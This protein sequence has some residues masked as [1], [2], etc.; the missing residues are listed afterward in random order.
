MPGI[1]ERYKKNIA[2]D[3]RKKG[4]SY[5]EIENRLYVPKSTLSFWLRK[6][7]LDESQIQKLKN[8][9]SEIARANALKKIE[10]TNKA[11]EEIKSFS[12]KSIGKISRRELWLIGIILYWRS[13]K[14]NYDLRNGLKFSSSN[15]SLIKLFLK[16]LIEIGKI[17][18]DEIDFDIFLKNKR[19][20]LKAINHWSSVTGFDKERFGHV[21][22]HKTGD[23]FLRI[24]VK[25]S[26]LLARQVAGWIKGIQELLNIHKYS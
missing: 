13:S 23:G 5:S 20:K 6:I 21:Y 1:L 24:R 7:K 3:M 16:W 12:S 22:Y 25:S 19:D 10:K 15:E 11:I 2:I 9:R 17:E 4:F 18:K 8:K 14:G 26:S